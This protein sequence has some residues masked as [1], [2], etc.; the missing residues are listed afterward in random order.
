MGKVLLC[1]CLCL[2]TVQENNRRKNPTKKPF[3]S[4]H[5]SKLQHPREDNS[6]APTLTTA[7]L[8]PSLQQST[9]L[10]TGPLPRISHA[11]SP[12]YKIHDALPLLTSQTFSR[13]TSTIQLRRPPLPPPNLHRPTLAV[14]TE[15]PS[16]PSPSI[17]CPIHFNRSNQRRPKRSCC[18]I[19]PSSR[20]HNR[21]DRR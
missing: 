16:T 4:H 19:S 8:L 21:S 6:A 14:V 5:R 2:F 9:P 18:S 15:S 10:T 13:T 20:A 1:C 12:G 11:P 7:D 3:C 17:P